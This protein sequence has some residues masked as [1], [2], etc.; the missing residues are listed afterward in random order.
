[1][2]MTESEKRLQ[3]HIDKLEA[4]NK[5]LR[6]SLPFS[7]GRDENKAREMLGKVYRHATS[8]YGS[9][10]VV[11]VNKAVN[12]LVHAYAEGNAVNEENKRLHDDLEL[13]HKRVSFRSKESLKF[14]DENKRLKSKLAAHR[15]EK[16]DMISEYLAVRNSIEDENK[17]LHRDGYR[18]LM[19]LRKWYH[20]VG[21][22]DGT[23]Q[24]TCDWEKMVEIVKELGLDTFKEPTP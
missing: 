10:G 4:E 7:S 6:D 5:Q 23:N 1:M 20:C 18:V 15:A 22:H 2:T 3:Q 11:N 13:L 21:C 16:L 8:I 17:R 24:H 9:I 19:A 12:A 14:E